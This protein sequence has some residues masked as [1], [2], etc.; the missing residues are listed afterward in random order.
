M[1]II[2]NLF[3]FQEL[4]D[5]ESLKDSLQKIYESCIQAGDAKNQALARMYKKILDDLPRNSR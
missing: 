4:E 3:F 1:R 2:H 5:P